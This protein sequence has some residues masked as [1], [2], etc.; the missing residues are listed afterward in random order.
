VQTSRHRRAAS[1]AVDLRNPCSVVILPPSTSSMHEQQQPRDLHVACVDPIRAA[2]T[3]YSTPLVSPLTVLIILHS[4]CSTKCRSVLHL[5]LCNPDCVVV[6]PVRSRCSFS[7]QFRI[8]VGCLLLIVCMVVF[9]L[10]SKKIPSVWVWNVQVDMN[11]LT[12]LIGNTSVM[13]LVA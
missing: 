2:P 10:R 11:L 12:Q 6:T 9:L 4:M 7:V 1:S 3:R 5:D 13:I 8:G